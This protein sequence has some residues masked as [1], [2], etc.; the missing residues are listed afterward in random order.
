MVCGNCGTSIADKAIV[1]YRC[2]APTSIPV[3]TA[4]ARKGGG[5]SGRSIV[6]LVLNVLILLSSGWSAWGAPAGSTDQILAGSLAALAAASV[7]YLLLRR[8]R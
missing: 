7:A 5:M 3:P 6:L 1:C 8:G 4:P 2:G